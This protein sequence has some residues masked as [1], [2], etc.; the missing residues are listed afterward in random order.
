[1]PEAPA[2]VP[3]RQQPAEPAAARAP[4]QAPAAAPEELGSLVP[5]A[6]MTQVRAVLYV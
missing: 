6:R 2:G 5:V 3:G 1:M 4:E